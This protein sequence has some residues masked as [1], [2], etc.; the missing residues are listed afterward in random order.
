MCARKALDATAPCST[1]GSM[2]ADSEEIDTL[3]TEIVLSL[4][5]L[6]HEL[7]H[8][9]VEAVLVGKDIEHLERVDRLLAVVCPEVEIKRV[10]TRLVEVERYGIYLCAELWER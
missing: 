1:V 3:R 5:M 6:L 8:A 2:E 4:G 9:V 7:L 10:G